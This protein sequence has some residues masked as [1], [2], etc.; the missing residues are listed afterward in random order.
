[1]I[2]FWQDIRFGLR[3]LLRN[4]VFTVVAVL[5]LALGI[6]ANTAIFSVTNAILLR[7][8]PVPNP[9]QLVYLHTSDFPRGMVQSGYGETSLNEPTYEELRNEKRAFSDLIAY[10]PLSFSKVSVRYGTEPEEAEADMVSG[11]FFSGLGVQPAIGRTFTPEDE[12]TH[13]LNAVLSYDY[14]NVR[15]AR[16]P[17]VLG[18]AIYVK[19]VPFT[20]VG[21]A[22]PGFIGL[23][24]G[25]PTDVW[26]P[27]QNRPDIQPWGNSA[28]SKYTLYGTPRYWCL[29]MM[30]RLAPGVTQQQA[31]A[32]LNPLFQRSA[33]VGIA[34][35]DPKEHPPQ[36]VFTPARG[37]EGLNEDFAQPLKVLM[38]MVGLVLVIACGNVSMLLVAR[39]AARQREFSLRMALGGSRARLF[40]Q[41]LTESL[42]LV[43][44]GG[45][46]G[47]LFA[48]WSTSALASWSQ[49]NLSLAPDQS[50]LLFTLGV[51]L[52]AALVFG[53]AP[54]R[55]VVRIPIG[56]VLKSAR[57][58]T[59]QDKAKVRSGHVVVAL[60]MAL[61]LMLL[62][63][64]GLL[65]RSLRNLENL[66]LGMRTN[67]LVVFGIG[68][69][70]PMHTDADT[71]RFY[72]AL[73]GRLRVLPGVRSVTLAENRIGA[74]VSSNTETYV[75]GKNPS[76]DKFSRMR[77]NGVGPDFFRTLGIPL[78]MGRDFTEADSQTATKVVVVNETFAKRYLANLNPLGHRA[79]FSD[80]TSSDQYMIV[81]VA[82]DSK[83]T[84]VRERPTPMA[85]FPYMQLTGISTTMHFELRAHGSPAAVLNEAEGAVRQFAPDL[86]LLQP[87]TQQQQFDDSISEDKL[88]ARLAMFFGFL[89]VVLVATGLYGTLAYRVSRRTAEIG[90]RMALGAQRSVVVLMILRQ[91]FVLAAVGLA[92]GLPTALVTSKLVESFLFGMTPNDPLALTLAVAILLAAALLAGF[93][94]ARKASRIDPMTALRNE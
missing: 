71:I 58:S 26:I 17:A 33:Y 32:E 55:S 46:F 67:G 38:A 68:P 31:L 85:Y 13:A 10:A 63:G 40:R 35:R 36:L 24:H 72:Q 28:Q 49:L 57:G 87:M 70:Q 88:I 37:I 12:N 89:A 8:L 75:D 52:A 4:P 5:T 19:G 93:V 92:I 20:I 7:F 64:A 51:S 79:A 47:W 6:G 43:I 15:L 41:L 2:S 84:E 11:N 29:L 45:L 39:N 42:L 61:C 91:V 27:L 90:I 73:L 21:I 62:V 23:E 65:V 18:Q 44:G 3:Q 30:G 34:D 54:L 74:G 22:A 60:Q 80:K 53:L 48:Q 59:G 16:N 66:N 94:P 50:V 1:M 86:P 14:W 76:G 82:A 56:L 77:W 78:L 69:Q 81:G 25:R 9:Q 83:Y